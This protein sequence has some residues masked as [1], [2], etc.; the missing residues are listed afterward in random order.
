MLALKWAQ[1]Y[2]EKI[3]EETTTVDLA[4]VSQNRSQGSLHVKHICSFIIIM[5]VGLL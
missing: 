1:S 3:G 5:Y 4:V 2:K